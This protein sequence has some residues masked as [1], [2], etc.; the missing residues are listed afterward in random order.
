MNGVPDAVIAVW[1]DAVVQ[2]CII[3]LIRNSVRHV[4]LKSWDELSRDL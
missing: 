4:S 3:H 1:S 2:T